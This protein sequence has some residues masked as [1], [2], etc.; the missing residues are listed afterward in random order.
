MKR[1]F[2]FGLML[3]GAF[4]LT[5]CAEELIDP[6]TMPEETTQETVT[7][8]NEGIPFKVYATLDNSTETKTEGVKD[9]EGHLKTNWVAGD[10]ITA[11]YEDDK[12]TLNGPITLTVSDIET[13]EF[14]IFQKC[15]Y[16]IRLF[17]E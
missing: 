15:F 17:F 1:I 11:F 6:T 16:F 13:G 4:A 9:N 12:N 10:Q 14:S 8:E 5:N 7:P 3:A 2:T